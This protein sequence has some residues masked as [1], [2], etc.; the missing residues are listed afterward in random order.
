[1]LNKT[2]AV[3]IFSAVLVGFTQNTPT[4]NNQSSD[5]A[6]YLLKSDT[7]KTWQVKRMPLDSLAL[8][9]RPLVCIKDIVSYDWTH[10]NMVLTQAGIRKVR[11]FFSKRTSKDPIPFVVTVGKER[12]Y[13]G[14]VFFI[15]TTYIIP[16]LP[17]IS[18][19]FK[20]TLLIFKSADGKPAD[21]RYD[22]KVHKAL[23][24]RHKIKK[25][26]IY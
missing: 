7:L 12:V 21:K 9:D 13:M 10:H 24:K 5:F 22:E 19:S 25:N 6:I 16:D 8:A 11:A 17:Y 2:I 20:R 4:S 23:Q 18:S 15:G 1:M 3:I 14:N 26:K